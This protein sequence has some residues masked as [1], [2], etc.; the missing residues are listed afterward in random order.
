MV[1]P[2]CGGSMM[3]DSEHV[4]CATCGEYLAEPNSSTASSS[5]IRI[6]TFNE[7]TAAA[8]PQVGRRLTTC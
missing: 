8:P 1:L 5:C 6:A 2:G 4:R 7:R 3:T